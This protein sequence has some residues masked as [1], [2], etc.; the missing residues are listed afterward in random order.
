MDLHYFEGNLVKK[1]RSSSSGAKR[2][3]LC[4]FVLACHPYQFDSSAD[5]HTRDLKGTLGSLASGH[6]FGAKRQAHASL[7]P[8]RGGL[9][10][11][12]T[13]TVTQRPVALKHSHE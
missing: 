2:F 5:E 1:A 3:K 9:R 6:H 12:L 13:E 10:A 8:F 11:P 4:L 7:C